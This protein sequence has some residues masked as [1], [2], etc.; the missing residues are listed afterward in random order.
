[1]PERSP[2]Q[3]TSP[4][5]STAERMRS[6]LE[7]R[8]A[9]TRLLVE[10]ESARHAGHAGAR[11]GGHFRVHIVSERFRGLSRLARHRLVYES[12]V[13][14]LGAAPGADSLRRAGVH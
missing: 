2:S 7:Q 13:A 4:W 9:P 3:A 12:V 10:D 5:S 8:L 11:E 6:A 14:S 1:M